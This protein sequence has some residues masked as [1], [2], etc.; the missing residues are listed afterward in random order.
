MADEKYKGLGRYQGDGPE[1]EDPLNVHI[2]SREGMKVAPST[3]PSEFSG[4]R[5]RFSTSGDT[6]ADR[7]TDEN[8][9]AEWRRNVGDVSR[10]M[11]AQSY[12]KGGQVGRV[13]NF[14]LKRSKPD[15][16]GGGSKT[17]FK[18]STKKGPMPW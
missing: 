7:A 11:K 17:N 5:G 12:A 3:A 6:A 9:N 4:K 15:F 1:P 10:G 13:G 14:G 8:I 2:R 16:A 18:M